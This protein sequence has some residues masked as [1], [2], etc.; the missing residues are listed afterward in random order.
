MLA[1][2]AAISWLRGSALLNTH[3][4]NRSPPSPKPASGRTLAAVQNGESAGFLMVVVQPIGPEMDCPVL[5]DRAG[6]P[7]TEAKI[8]AFHV[9][10]AARS[11]GIGTALQR[12]VLRLAEELGCY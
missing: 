3:S 8:C 12:E 1:H 11:Q 4:C 6:N 10:E 7:L 5:C 9:R 2:F